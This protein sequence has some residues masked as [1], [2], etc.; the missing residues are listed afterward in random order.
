MRPSVKLNV[1]QDLRRKGPCP[2]IPL[3]Q[4]R[5]LVMGRE[6]IACRGRERRYPNAVADRSR[7]RR[8]CCVSASLLSR[9]AQLT[10]V[11]RLPKTFPCAITQRFDGAEAVLSTGIEE[12]LSSF[13]RD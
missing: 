12:D 2:A 9:L 10:V 13:G 6:Y 8:C 11:R 4:H 1:W 7:G 3:Y 5:R